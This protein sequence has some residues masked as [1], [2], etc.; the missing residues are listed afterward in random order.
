VT[1]RYATLRRTAPDEAHGD[2]KG[3]PRYG[4][5]H[6]PRRTLAPVEPYAMVT[7]QKVGPAERIVRYSNCLRVGALLRLFFIFNFNFKSICTEFV[8]SLYTTISLS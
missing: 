5:S 6:R 7:L 3:V 2:E 4:A 8:V 1:L